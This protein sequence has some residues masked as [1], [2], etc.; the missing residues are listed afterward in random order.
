MV[1]IKDVARIAGVNKSTVS[2]YLN[3][4]LKLKDETVKRIEAA[5]KET[6]YIPN[7][8]AAAIKTKKSNTIAIVIPSTKNITFAEIAEAINDVIALKGYSMVI[9]TTDDNLEKEKNAA[10]K[11]L[12]NR[13][14]GAIFITEP[15][16]DK[17]MSHIDLLEENN[18]KT[19]LINRF[20]EENKYSNIS[21]NYYDGVKKVIKY[22]NGLNYDKV[23]LI[24]GWKNQ[25]QSKIYLKA[26]KD[27]YKELGVGYSKNMVYYSDYDVEKIRG[28]IKE[29]IK[30]KVDAIFTVSDRSAL[31]AL[32]VI[33]EEGL[34]IPEDIAVIGS[35]NTE[36]SRL[37]KM[38]SLDGRGEEI[39]KEAAEVL[40][41]K[42]RG[43]KY[44]NF[45]LMNSNVV[46]RNTTR[47]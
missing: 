32:E 11:I 5:I 25:D 8:A 33:E 15:K 26:Y 23:G 46:V 9:Y 30:K 2:R 41:E 45:I 6:H 3:G 37:I 21:I 7:K 20:Y 31:I 4:S 36:F 24:L 28:L 12:E 40:I 42:L 35:G 22:L 18:I 47:K 1:T 10:F 38:T 39:G 29:L 34:R 14:S 27:A 17:D 19:V 13:F 16:G 44:N 43:K